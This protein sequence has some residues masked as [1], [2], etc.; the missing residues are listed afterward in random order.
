MYQED[1]KLY[2][3]V[4]DPKEDHFLRTYELGYVDLKDNSY[5]T[6]RT[7]EERAWIHDYIYRGDELIYSLITPN[8]EEQSLEC[9]VIRETGDKKEV[10]QEGMI[11]WSMDAATFVK[12]GN[13]IFYRFSPFRENN[14]N[15]YDYEN[16]LFKL[17]TELKSILHDET[18]MVSSEYRDVDFPTHY[19]APHINLRANDHYVYFSKRSF[20]D[21]VVVII[22]S[23]TEEVREVEVGGNITDYT[24]VGVKLFYFDA[25][26]EMYGHLAVQAIDITTGEKL[27]IDTM[28]RDLSFANIDQQGDVF[29]LSYGVDAFVYYDASRD[30]FERVRLNEVSPIIR[31]TFNQFINTNCYIEDDYVYLVLN[32]SQRYSKDDS[33]GWMISTIKI[34]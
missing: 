6:L 18:S 11:L 13:E 8:H 27:K 33:T 26:K 20:Y 19:F 16:D 17:T 5:H 15:N 21:S 23:L 4:N 2:V 24:L 30:I 28:I 9:Q 14:E 7:F 29:I 34:K 12:V 25:T 31:K 3:L 22:D 10:L 1:H 32:M